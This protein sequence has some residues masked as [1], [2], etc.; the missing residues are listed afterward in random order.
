MNFDNT[1][2]GLA[3]GLSEKSDPIWELFMTRFSSRRNEVISL[4]RTFKELMAP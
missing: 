2:L 4:S 3:K 1:F